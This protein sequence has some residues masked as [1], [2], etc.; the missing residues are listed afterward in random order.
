[1]SQTAVDYG[2]IRNSFNLLTDDH[3]SIRTDALQEF[4]GK[5]IPKTEMSK[6][7]GIPRASTYQSSIKL[8]AGTLKSMVAIAMAAD[9]AVDL[10]NS[11]DEA[12][13]WM[14]AP[15][16]YYF[17]QSP[18]DVCLLGNGKAVIEFLKQKLEK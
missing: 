10:L 16:S 12:R 15:N 8:S 11:T 4:L 6:L 13:R 7:L 1:M 17:G 3:K 14:L 9:L 2:S 5:D 18:F